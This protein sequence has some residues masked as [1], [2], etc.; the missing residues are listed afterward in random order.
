MFAYKVI[1]LEYVEAHKSLYERLRRI[2]EEV[3][4]PVKVFND[5]YGAAW[6][7]IQSLPESQKDA[8]VKGEEER[9]YWLSMDV[10][11]EAQ[12]NYDE[13][14]RPIINAIIALEAVATQLIIPYPEYTVDEALAVNGVFYMDETHASAA[15]AVPMYKRLDVAKATVHDMLENLRGIRKHVENLTGVGEIARAQSLKTGDIIN[16]RIRHYPPGMHQ[17]VSLDDALLHDMQIHEVMRDG[18]IR[19]VS[20]KE[21]YNQYFNANRK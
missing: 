19:P 1:S 5:K 11:R 20:L 8:Y 15:D 17:P 6:D 2:Q 7:R 9:I 16:E 21:F 4:K 12:I 13:L 14:A 3:S 10:N 18:S